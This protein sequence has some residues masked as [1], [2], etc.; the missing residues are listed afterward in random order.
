MAGPGTSLSLSISQTIADLDSVTASARKVSLTNW[1]TTLPTA[2][3]SI[4]NASDAP[5]FL[6]PADTETVSGCSVPAGVSA[7]FGP[8]ERDT[9]NALWL[10][11]T[12]TGSA[13]ITIV[14]V[15]SEGL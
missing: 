1:P 2:F 11:G 4:H 8:F 9:A 12:G 13:Y 6:C 15:R 14:E 5:V 10:Y 3:V 7:P